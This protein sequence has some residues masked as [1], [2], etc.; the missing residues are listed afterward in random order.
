MIEKVREV[1]Y[2]LMFAMPLLA[3]SSAL[4]ICIFVGILKLFR[5]WG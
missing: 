4:A 2:L 3:V 1:V 5:L